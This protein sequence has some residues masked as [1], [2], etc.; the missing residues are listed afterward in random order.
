MRVSRASIRGAPPQTRL[1]WAELEEAIALKG[2]I[3]GAGRGK[4]L[5]PYT[6]DRPKCL[7]P[8]GGRP[9]LDWI[10]GA[11]REVGLDQLVF[12][13]GYRMADIERHAPELTFV[14]NSQWEHNNILASLM[15]AEPFMAD[16]FVCA[17]SDT[18]ITSRL[19][20]PLM[21]ATGDITLALDASWNERH[22]A[23]PSQYDALVE[24]TWVDGDRVTRIE[25]VLPPGDAVGEFT[26]VVRFSPAGARR[27]ID[28]FHE[29]RQRF[30][31]RPFHHGKTFEVAY[32]VD[33]V[34][35]LIDRGEP[36]D[37]VACANAYAEI[38]TV[39]DY[40][41]ANRD[42]VKAFI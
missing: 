32:L 6:D 10:L 35:E 19:L 5:R 23:R 16:G 38:D 34:Q 1:P 42:W 33:L 29:C 18:I 39:E 14:E 12:V 7:V 3:I 24:G 8:V 22:G 4:R 27:F 30:A 9:I 36:V 17:Y 13:G 21:T 25:R 37:H 11:F 15:Y 26:G 28:A 40:Q 2:I 20:E 41:L 31:G